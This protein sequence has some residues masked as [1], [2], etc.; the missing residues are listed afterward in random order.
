MGIFDPV[1]AYEPDVIDKKKADLSKASFEKKAALSSE[2]AK[3]ELNDALLNDA[4]SYQ[5]GTN[6][7]GQR[8]SS[9]ND[10]TNYDSFED[11]VTKWKNNPENRASQAIAA[12]EILGKPASEVSNQ[13]IFGLNE[14]SRNRASDILFEGQENFFTDNE[15]AGPVRPNDSESGMPV[16]ETNFQKLGH[17]GRDIVQARNP[18]TGKVVSE[19]LNNPIDNAAFNSIGRFGNKAG[20]DAYDQTPAGREAILEG[21]DRTAGEVAGDVG[22]MAGKFGVNTGA[23]AYGIGDITARTLMQPINAA[24]KQIDKI[25]PDWMKTGYTLGQDELAGNFAETNKIIDETLQSDQTKLSVKKKA[26]ADEE[27]NAGSEARKKKWVDEGK[28]TGLGAEVVDMTMSIYEGAKNSLDNPLAL[29]DIVG[30]SLPQLATGGIFGKAAVSKTIANKTSNMTSKEASKYVT[31]KEGK[32]LIDSVATRTGIATEAVQESMI[33]AVNKQGEVLAMS[34][35]ELGEGSNEYVALRSNGMSHEQ[36]RQEIANKTFNTTMAVTAAISSGASKFMGTGKATGKLLLGADGSPIT[37]GIVKKTAKGALDLGKKTVGETGQEIVQ[38]GGGEFAGNLAEKLFV[39]E[40]QKLLEGVGTAAGTG[41][42]AGGVTGGGMHAAGDTAKAL[43]AGARLGARTAGK[44]AGSETVNKV[45]EKLIGTKEERLNKVFDNPEKFKGDKDKYEKEVNTRLA[46]SEKEWAA[47]FQA[48]IDALPDDENKPRAAADI[49]MP[50]QNKILDARAE[51]K[52]AIDSFKS[53][54]V[55]KNINS[56]DPETASTAIVASKEMSNEEK[57]TKLSESMDSLDKNDPARKVVKKHYQD[58][59]DAIVDEILSDLSDTQG[60]E[61]TKKVDTANTKKEL[62]EVQ[63]NAVTEALVERPLEIASDPNLTPEEVQEQTKEI[64]TKIFEK[65]KNSK[66]PHA[67]KMYRTAKFLETMTSEKNIFKTA[68]GAD[69]KHI[70]E[71]LADFYGDGGSKKSNYQGVGKSY[72]QYFSA[73]FRGDKESMRD[74]VDSMRHAKSAQ[75][76]KHMKLKKQLDTFQE[77][78]PNFPED[79]ATGDRKGPLKGFPIKQHKSLMASVQS[80]IDNV[81]KLLVLQDSISRAADSI[82]TQEELEKSFK[83]SRNREANEKDYLKVAKDIHNANNLKTLANFERDYINTLSATMPKEGPA[84]LIEILENKRK[85]LKSIKEVSSTTTEVPELKFSEPDAKQQQADDLASLDIVFAEDPA[86][87]ISINN[88]GEVT[89]SKEKKPTTPPPT[90][91][92]KTEVKEAPLTFD[93]PVEKKVVEPAAKANLKVLEADT[94]VTNIVEMDNQGRSL[95]ISKLQKNKA[96]NSPEL[97]ERGD[98]RYIHAMKNGSY[99]VIID[100]ENNEIV[101]SDRI[102]VDLPSVDV[103]QSN[104]RDSTSVEKN[105]PVKEEAEKAYIEPTASE[106][107]I[108]DEANDADLVP[109]YLISARSKTDNELRQEYAELVKG[110]ELGYS[111]KEDMHEAENKVEIIEYELGKRA[112]NNLAPNDEVIINKKGTKRKV[113]KTGLKTSGGTPAVLLEIPAKGKILAREAKVLTPVSNL[114][115]VIN[116]I[117]DPVD[118]KTAKESTPTVD[119]KT[120]K[121][122]VET[123]SVQQEPENPAAE[124]TFGDVDPNINNTDMTFDDVNIKEEIEAAIKDTTKEDTVENPVVEKEIADN[125]TGALVANKNIKADRHKNDPE[126]IDDLDMFIAENR[127]GELFGLLFGSN[128]D[129]SKR[130]SLGKNSIYGNTEAYRGYATLQNEKNKKLKNKVVADLKAAI[131]EI[132]TIASPDKS[133]TDI[134]NDI[135][136]KAEEIFN[137]YYPRSADTHTNKLID[138]LEDKSSISNDNTLNESQAEFSNVQKEIQEILY[139]SANL[140]LIRDTIGEVSKDNVVAKVKKD[141]K[142]LYDKALEEA[143]NKVSKKYDSIRDITELLVR[144]DPKNKSVFQIL[145]NLLARVLGKQYGGLDNKVANVDDFK[146]LGLTEKHKQVLQLMHNFNNFNFDDNPQLDIGQRKS[147]TDAFQDSIITNEDITQYDVVSDP[148]LTLLDNDGNI[149][150]NLKDSMLITAFTYTYG[151]GKETLFNGAEDI[152]RII[153]RDT[154]EGIDPLTNNIFKNIGSAAPTIEEQ[155]GIQVLRNMGMAIDPNSPEN[156]PEKLAQ[157]IGQRVVIGLVKQG[158]FEY[159]KVNNGIISLARAVDKEARDKVERTEKSTG[160]L[161]IRTQAFDSEY[162]DYVYEN[163]HSGIQKDIDFLNKGDYLKIMDELLGIDSNN[164]GIHDKP[165]E[166][167]GKRLQGSITHQSEDIKNDVNEMQKRK[168]ISHPH[169]SN[170]FAN[171]PENVRMSLGGA[172]PVESLETTNAE[173]KESEESKIETIRKEANAVQEFIEQGRQDKPFYY[174][175]AVWVNERMGVA[176]NTINYQS[177]KLQRFLFPAE[178]WKM[179]AKTGHDSDGLSDKDIEERDYLF[180]AIALGLGIP[181]DKQ[182]G[183]NSKN[184]MLADFYNYNTLGDPWVNL[185]VDKDGKKKQ[186]QHVKDAVEVIKKLLVGDSIT[187]AEESILE[188]STAAFGENMHSYMALVAI[189]QFD[190]AREASIGGNPVD[191]TD[192]YMPLEVDGVT[193]GTANSMM[194]YAPLIEKYRNKYNATGIS[195]SGDKYNDFL[196]WTDPKEGGGK[197]LYRQLAKLMADTNTE[198]REKFANTV[199]DLTDLFNTYNKM[200]NSDDNWVA[201]TEAED[202]YNKAVNKLR[203]SLFM[204]STGKYSTSKKAFKEVVDYVVT[205]PNSAGSKKFQKVIN[206]KVEGISNI[207]PEF[208]RAIA[209]DPLLVFAYMA[210]TKSMVNS[211]FS[212]SY[213]TLLQNGTEALWGMKN[214]DIGTVKYQ[215]AYDAYSKIYDSITSVMTSLV[216]KKQGKG[217]EFGVA[218][219]LSQAIDSPQE[220]EG[221]KDNEAFKPNDFFTPIGSNIA[222]DKAFKGD[223]SP[224]DMIANIFDTFMF[225]IL[226][227]SFDAEYGEMKERRTTITSAMSMANYLFKELETIRLDDARTLAEV[228][229][230]VFSNADKAEVY[231]NM[232]KAGEM[233]TVKSP[234]SQDHKTFTDYPLIANKRRQALPEGVDNALVARVPPKS[235]GRIPVTT[236]EIPTKD[237]SGNDLPFTLTNVATSSGTD[238]Q[239]GTT[240][241]IKEYSDNIGV[242]AL[243][244]AI[245][246]IDAA[247]NRRTITIYDDN[248][249]IKYTIGNIHDA[250]LF[251]PKHGKEIGQL[252]NENHLDIH[253]KTNIFEAFKE[254]TDKFRKHSE[255][256]LNSDNGSTIALRLVDKFNNDMAGLVDNKNKALVDADPTLAPDTIRTA[257]NKWFGNLDFFT[258]IVTKENK[259]KHDYILTNSQFASWK[260]FKENS[261]NN[262]KNIN[263]YFAKQ[264]AENNLGRDDEVQGSGPTKSYTDGAFESDD[265][266]ETD[267]AFT[268]EDISEETESTVQKDLGTVNKNSSETGEGYNASEFYD[269]KNQT[270]TSENVLALFDGMVGKGNVQENSAH[271][272]HLRNVVEELIM[273]VIGKV[274]FKQ[275]DKQTKKNKGFHFSNKNTI[276]MVNSTPDSKTGMINGITM[277]M[278]ASEIMAHEF[279]H[280]IIQVAIDNN[281]DA[282]RLFAKLYRSVKAQTTYEAFLPTDPDTGKQLNDD[283]SVAIAKETYDYV[284]R[285]YNQASHLHEFVTFGLTNEAFSKHLETIEIQNVDRSKETIG[286]LT[287]IENIVSKAIDFLFTLL[288]KNN[289]QA[290]ETLFSLVQKFSVSQAKGVGRLEASLRSTNSTLAKGDQYINAAVKYALK[291]IDKYTSHYLDTRKESTGSLGDLLSKTAHFPLVAGKAFLGDDKVLAEEVGKQIRNAVGID[292]SSGWHSL[293]KEMR[294]TDPDNL[295]FYRFLREKKQKI[296]SIR[297]RAKSSVKKIITKS[298]G[299]RL[300][301]NEWLALNN[302]VLK[303]DLISLVDGIDIAEAMKL[304]TNSRHRSQT[305]D[306]LEKRIA[307]ISPDNIEFYKNQTK[308]LGHYMSLGIVGIDYQLFNA[309]N[310]AFDNDEHTDKELVDSLDKLATLR[311]IN[312]T[313]AQTINVVKKLYAEESVRDVNHN[314]IEKMLFM[315]KEFKAESLK[316]NFNGDPLLMMKGYTK[317][318]FD[319][320]KDMKVANIRDGQKL[321]DQG[322]TKVEGELPQSDVDGSSKNILHMYVSNQGIVQPY[323]SGGFNLTAQ[324]MAGMN[325]FESNMRS[326]SISPLDFNAYADMSAAVQRSKQESY[327][328]DVVDFGKIYLAPSLDENAN[329][330]NFRF[331]MS[332]KNKVNLLG[333]QDKAQDVLASMYGSMKDK[334]ESKPFNDRLVDLMIMDYEITKDKYPKE[335]FKVISRASDDFK[336]LPTSAQMQLNKM[337]GANKPIM[338]RKDLQDIVFGYRKWSAADYLIEK[339]EKMFDMTVYPR[340]KQFLRLFEHFY[341]WLVSKAK[342][343]IVV[344][345]PVVPAMNMLSNII[346]LTMKG[347]P[348]NRAIVDMATAAKEMMDYQATTEKLTILGFEIKLATDVKKKKKYIEEYKDLSKR[349]EVNALAPLID[350][351]LFQTIAEDINP[352]TESLSRI[353]DGMYHVFTG[354]NSTGLTDKAADY[355]PDVLKEVYSINALASETQG[356]KFMAKITQYSDLMARYALYKELSRD[357]S[358]SEQSK[359]EELARTFIEYDIPSS[360]GL[361]YLNDMGILMF[362]KFPLRIASIIMETIQKAPSKAIAYE[363]AQQVLGDVEDITDANIISKGYSLLS[364][365]LFKGPLDIT[366]SAYNLSNAYNAADGTYD[367]LLGF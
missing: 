267:D 264:E 154:K 157:S 179:S 59:N 260:A 254:I 50:L 61:P 39:N 168:W 288:N 233:I 231:E 44:V 340:F 295:P 164:K 11:S 96:K 211:L 358:R 140:E 275:L 117:P 335:D 111:T 15:T 285:N 17:Y 345:T 60:S 342:N 200:D 46:A 215:E 76:D 13:D 256:L 292:K 314:G 361:Q 353:V 67:K 192:I 222:V 70:S 138:A 66:S 219:D 129:S 153:A 326:H 199:T 228:K 2:W 330:K 183:E 83:L 257:I 311:S 208:V 166:G 53:T 148:F 77:A 252:A 110:S 355:V 213:E 18:I 308:S 317:E 242:K 182:E 152:N 42:I 301:N 270:I 119:T 306:A 218:E 97:L 307:N 1:L 210:G 194:Q 167:T 184:Q 344:L 174:A 360:A 86:I 19:E 141:M 29:Q 241:S 175:M 73:Y 143:S 290:N 347:V 8:F 64:Y 150:Q 75:V 160:F 41:G 352:E 269:I 189:A 25:L 172:A 94:T 28:L 177:S 244:Y 102:N 225:P 27:W 87:N 304:L 104:L 156:Y 32:K 72:K 20:R 130:Q 299:R 300:S 54:S 142:D 78:N 85:Y 82:P 287:A 365:D 346:L 48:K 52:N 303:T 322:Y 180:L 237:A 91:S 220:V 35:A 236:K 207:I 133:I 221:Y 71:V 79:K 16:M 109:Q 98:A 158:Y 205:H 9:P 309:Y 356:G 337:F 122:P 283:Q 31:S 204:Y 293:I 169:L 363:M 357:K 12:G 51:A 339:A 40:D 289:K 343:V 274:S 24:A 115:P 279:V 206:D 190:T 298:F 235:K 296:D 34:E 101:A 55:D 227:T 144:K 320:M 291:P 234:S 132:K 297:D 327:K 302:V 214:N 312:Y 265:T 277:N 263:E 203:Q 318:N 250:V 364:M 187:K 238:A 124:F 341:Q 316:L 262:G 90:E 113:L 276:R 334:E 271:I 127:S 201:K 47:E 36:A 146:S 349:L 6:P 162:G 191:A 22:A 137:A 7:K 151:R 26:A 128:T 80:T 251:N 163:V 92:P 321:L 243:I 336:M 348:L 95:K 268:Y 226:D 147:L 155:L 134:H 139:K 93:T 62:S 121:E 313:D 23:T 107:V 89:P 108:I 159:T 106:K 362:T 30:T 223:I 255:Y 49:A 149:P 178:D 354:G 246:P 324:Q 258:D 88:M 350:A 196:S 325:F 230:D 224:K 266:S 186:G 239:I 212:S 3:Q 68:K 209:K 359:V 280:N 126:A 198:L 217:F 123:A 195:F 58:T 45:K 193:N 99:A 112:M 43:G 103:F 281:P 5:G 248:G 125:S 170:L 319:P 229:G 333:K 181:I 232:L 202:I 100:L 249:E 331:L 145:P 282:K 245:I 10:L 56:S 135:M 329:I 259:D 14:Q 63:V 173:L 261:N 114:K 33:N 188:E 305:I 240:A 328:G 105:T 315:H 165:V 161:R 273:P 216:L 253:A 118:Q 65:L 310:M 38:E 57:H 286:A 294:K 81:D 69:R 278:S 247:N 338:M 185:G 171:L 131:K 284:F 176:S 37:D 272:E 4:D 116:Y 366:D 323:Q 367:L 120:E 136:L 84:K 351:G 332:E 21:T 197:D 74:S